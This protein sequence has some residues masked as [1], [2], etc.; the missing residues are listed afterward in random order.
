[1]MVMITIGDN[2]ESACRQVRR[3]K[4]HPRSRHLQKVIVPPISCDFGVEMTMRHYVT[5][6]VVMM[7]LLFQNRVR[8]AGLRRVRNLYRLQRVRDRHPL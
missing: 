8:E 6:I 3:Q 2:N 5:M 7:M 4:W 1:M